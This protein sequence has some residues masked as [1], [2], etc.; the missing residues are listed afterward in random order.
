MVQGM[1]GRKLGMAQV[2][3]EGG[4]TVGVTVVELGPCT[5]AQ[6][7]AGSKVQLGFGEI[8]EKLLTKPLQG[9]FL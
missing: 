7:T 1:I 4:H 6:K 8:R 3:G 9:H 5:V 2:F